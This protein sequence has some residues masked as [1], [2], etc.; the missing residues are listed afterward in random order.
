MIS[1]ASQT[2]RQPGKFHALG[3]PA[4]CRGFTAWIVQ[5]LRPSRKTHSP[6]ARECS[7]ERRAIRMKMREALHEFR[8]RQPEMLRDALGLALA[9]PHEAR[10][11]AA[12]A[13]SLAKVRFRN[14][15]HALDLA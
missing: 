13:A 4:H 1:I 9:Q 12:I 10:P 11:A 3:K 5:V 8:D 2:S 15:R 7:I 14:F 6:F